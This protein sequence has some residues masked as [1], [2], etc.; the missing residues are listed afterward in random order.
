MRRVIALLLALLSISL[1]FADVFEHPADLDDP[2]FIGF[3]SGFSGSSI[4]ADYTQTRRVERLGLELVSSGRMLI[5]EGTGMAWL[6]E[7]PYKSIMIVGKDSIR[8]QIGDGA[9]TALDVSGNQIYLSIADAIENVFMGNFNAVGDVFSIY[10]ETEDDR[11][12]IGLIP[13]DIAVSSFLSYIIINGC[14][15]IFSDVL[16]M[17]NDGNSVLYSFSGIE[18]RELTDEETKAYSI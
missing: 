13:K 4:A 3:C 5:Q 18:H 16:V 12:Q 9:A 15:N 17:Q 10:Y 7:T 11:W 14:D 8:Q 1:L 6:S 2:E